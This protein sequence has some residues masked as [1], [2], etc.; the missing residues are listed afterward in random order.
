MV[1]LCDFAPLR[2]VIVDPYLGAEAQR[3]TPSSRFS[4]PPLWGHTI[5]SD[6][7]IKAE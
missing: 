2:E 6:Q 3:S 4:T 1:F 7:L 5:T